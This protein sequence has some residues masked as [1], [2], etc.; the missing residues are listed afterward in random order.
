[1]TQFNQPH[2]Q[3][4]PTVPSKRR[5][6]F[7]LA[8]AVA[9]LVWTVASCGG[10]AALV[11]FD[12]FS[13]AD[14]QSNGP[15][16]T[17]PPVVTP[18][19]AAA[20]TAAEPTLVAGRLQPGSRAENATGSRVNVRR[21]PGVV[22]KPDGDILAQMNP[23]ETVEILGWSRTADN[24]IWWPVRFQPAQGAAVDGWVAESTDSAV[25]ILV[26]LP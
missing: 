20:D 15:A 6:V 10:A 19:V 22:G 5:S 12:E 21:S 8:F 14:F 7:W 23:G 17:P 11:G 2:P 9:F 24:L 13:L 18:V 1:M 16:W 4:P 26:P 25:Q 3:D